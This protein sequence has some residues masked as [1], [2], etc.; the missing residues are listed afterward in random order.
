MAIL[1]HTLFMCT[2]CVTHIYLN[3]TLAHYTHNTYTYTGGVG[4][5][6]NRV[7]QYTYQHQFVHEGSKGQVLSYIRHLRGNNIATT[8]VFVWNFTHGKFCWN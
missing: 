7:G 6:R 2:H 4:A 8:F 3:N 5:T 1:M